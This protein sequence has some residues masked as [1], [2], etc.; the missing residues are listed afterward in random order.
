MSQGDKSGGPRR[1]LGRGLGSLIP[2]APL[3]AD[4]KTDD[5]AE[6]RP[7]PP[8]PPVPAAEGSAVVP[9]A[10]AD[11]QV[12]VGAYFADLPVAQITPNARQPRTVFEEEALAE[13]VHSIKEIGLLQPVV[14][15]KTGEEQYELIMGER[16]WRA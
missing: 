14:V 10:P 4:D 2:T 16:R 12:P 3:A 8:A 5:G 13:L 11:V 6:P 9:T 1:G 7:T 15:R